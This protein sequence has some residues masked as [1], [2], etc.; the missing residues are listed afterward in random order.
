[1]TQHPSSA[2]P[3]YYVAPFSPDGELIG[4]GGRMISELSTKWLGFC[5]Q[6]IASKGAVFQCKIPLPTLQHITVQVTSGSGTALV[7]FLV[8]DHPASSAVALTGQRAT[9]EAEVLRMF[10][11][12]MRRVPTVQEL[13][14]TTK[15]FDCL[16]AITE[17]PLYGVVLWAN[18]SISESDQQLVQELENHLAAAL[19][20]VGDQPRPSAS[21]Q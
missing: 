21:E 15:P 3:D 20:A 14:R 18:Q 7:S 12:S 6:L 16:L 5:N 2:K 17:R 19:L 4:I 11:E 10:V 9:A 8:N 1:M 13:A